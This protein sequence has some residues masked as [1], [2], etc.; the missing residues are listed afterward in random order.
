MERSRRCSKPDAM[1]YYGI[2]HLNYVIV[3]TRISRMTYSKCSH[4]QIEPHYHTDVIISM[5]Q[6]LPQS[7]REAPILSAGT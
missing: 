7:I 6:G 5:L 1:F 4:P 3:I 2:A